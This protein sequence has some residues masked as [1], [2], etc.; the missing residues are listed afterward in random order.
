MFCVGRP[1]AVALWLA[2]ALVFACPLPAAAGPKD[3]ARVLLRQGN[4]HYAAGEY[5]K[6]LPLFQKAQ[7]LYP[8]YK[9][10]YNIA[11]T[12]YDL[13]Q[14]VKA[15]EHFERFLKYR[16]K[17]AHP[18]IL[19]LASSRF[20]T[21][22]GQLAGVRIACPH[23]GAAVS[24]DGKK[25]DVTPMDRTVFFRPGP[26]LVRVT[27][28]GFVPYK[29]RHA[30]DKGAYRT[31]WVAMQPSAKDTPRPDPTPTP[32]PKPQV[33]RTKTI[34]GFVSLGVGLALL[35]GAGALY[36]LSIPRGSD[37]HDQYRELTAQPVSE[38]DR[39]RLEQLR[40]DMDRARTELLVAN[41]LAGAGV[42][43]VAVAAIQFAT[44]T[45][46]APNTV[47][48]AFAPEVGVWASPRGGGVS[49]QGGF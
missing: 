21:I 29:L 40:Q 45:E 39:P 3:E 49:L 17:V 16:E 30:F 5:D 34:I 22:K 48:A 12:L 19:E 24:I 43:A 44:R 6:A 15:A 32:A 36:G 25:V 31:L 11:N 13:G 41:I 33:S 38:P 18:D 7:Q 4:K 42:V 9:L 28:D 26:H 2:T 23:T 10:E 1:T 37:A 8:S 20:R 46:K 14:L 47:R 35:G 27:L